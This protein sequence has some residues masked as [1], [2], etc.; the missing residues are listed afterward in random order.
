M[1]Q[2]R[3][4]LF[5]NNAQFADDEFNRHELLVRQ[6]STHQGKIAMLCAA[7]LFGL[8]IFGVLTERDWLAGSMLMATLILPF[9]VLSWL[10]RGVA[11]DKVEAY[12]EQDWLLL[13]FA[14]GRFPELSTDIRVPFAEIDLITLESKV[15]CEG[16]LGTH[17]WRQYRIRTSRSGETPHVLINTFRP[18]HLL[19]KDLQWLSALPSVQRIDKHLV[20]PRKSLTR[21]V[22][23]RLCIREVIE[24]QTIVPTRLLVDKPVFYV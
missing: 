23:R 13:T 4:R 7:P 20:A 11:Q 5:A 16:R 14:C 19:L 10:A 21:S 3:I 18:M 8:F 9:A 12:A 24:G 6:P 22:F 1:Q 17:R 2:K 15:V